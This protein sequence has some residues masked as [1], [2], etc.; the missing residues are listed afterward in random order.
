M[1]TTEGDF[2]AM[3]QE[4]RKVEEGAEGQM[5]MTAITATVDRQQRRRHW[6]CRLNSYLRGAVSASRGGNSCT[7]EGAGM[8]RRLRDIYSGS[9]GV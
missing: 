2:L 5:Y 3:A 1:V 9:I 4:A 7:R 6:H 8:T